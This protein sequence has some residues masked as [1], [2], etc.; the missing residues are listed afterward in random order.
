MTEDDKKAAEAINDDILDD[1]QGGIAL[2]RAHAGMAA[3]ITG[4]STQDHII[5][6][7]ETPPLKVSY[8]LDEV[9]QAGNTVTG[10]VNVNTKTRR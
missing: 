6:A 9:T 2:G 5:N 7:G 1:A 8:T 3:T 4:L 10:K